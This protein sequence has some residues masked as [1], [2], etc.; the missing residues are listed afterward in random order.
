M[1]QSEP[2]ADRKT[3]PP[4]DRKRLALDY[5]RLGGH[6][7]KSRPDVVARSNNAGTSGHIAA[8][9]LRFGQRRVHD[10]ACR[11]V[12]QR[13]CTNAWHARIYFPGE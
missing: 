2:R 8:I 1:S 3:R 4:A 13:P 10:L 9:S 12:N 7:H 11:C 6:F 5:I